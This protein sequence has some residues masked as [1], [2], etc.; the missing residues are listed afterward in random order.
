MQD[1]FSIHGTILIE[2]H[3]RLRGLRFHFSYFSF[4]TTHIFCTFSKLYK[5]A[6]RNSLIKRH[7]YSSAF[8]GQLHAHIICVAQCSY[9]HKSATLKSQYFHFKLILIENND[10]EWMRR[11]HKSPPST[12]NKIQRKRTKKHIHSF[13]CSANAARYRPI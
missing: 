4:F 2:Y 11:A 7:L 12:T 6:T 8:V 10:T 9:I 13:G 1:R 5:W 3:E